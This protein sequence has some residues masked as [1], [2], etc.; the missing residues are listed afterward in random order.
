MIYTL[1]LRV[2]SSSVFLLERRRLY[3]FL[4]KA[5][6]MMISHEPFILILSSPSGA[7]KSTLS[8]ALLKN[9]VNIEMSISY[10]TRAK[11]SSEIDGKDYN[12][13]TKEEFEKLIEADEFLE[14]ATVYGNLYGTPKTKVN[15]IL[16][17]GKD[18]L[19]DIDWQGTI[20]LKSMIPESIVSVFIL[21]PSMKE[22]E[23]RLRSRASE[24]EE[25]IQ[26]RLSK[27]LVEISHW[28][29]YDHVIVNNHIEESLGFI[30]A[31]ISVERL[32]RA[33]L[34]KIADELM[35]HEIK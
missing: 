30:E 33:N 16:K 7:G 15:D 2:S 27:S 6:S 31:I 23:K 1:V 9:D 28:G 14:Y 25:I 21:P 13:V 22:L 29:A 5:N 18:V 26:K 4:G 35:N 19:F 12:F 10:T 17:S 24:S 8:R 11:R 34:W 32:N 3:I 20:Q